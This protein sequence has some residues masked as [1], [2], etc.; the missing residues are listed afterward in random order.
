MTEDNGRA[1]ARRWISRIILATFLALIILSLPAMCQRHESPSFKYS[2]EANE[3]YSDERHQYQPYDH[4]HDH[5]HVHVHDHEHEHEHEEHDPIR[6]DPHGHEYPP[7]KAS[8]KPSPPHIKNYKDIVVRAIGST[9]IISAAPFL[10]LFFVP[11]DNTEQSEW[12]LKILLSFASGGLLGD[13]FLHLIPHAMIPHSHGSSETH[14]HSHSNSHDEPGHHKHDI[15]VGL[16]ILLGLIVFLMVEKAVR[17]VKG[18]HGHS[19]EKK[20]VLV[21]K[22]EGKKEERKEEKKEGKK[23][24]KKE[25]KKNSGKAVSKACKTPESDIKIA[26]YLN[27]AADFLHNF[28]DGL[29]IGASYMAGDSIGYVTTFMILLHEIPHEIGDFA[30]LIQSGYSKSKAMKMQ[31]VTA[32]GALLGTFISLLAEGMGDFATK[33]ILPFTAGG[34]IYIATVSVIPELLTA[35]KLWQSVQE[36]SALLVGVSLMVFMSNIE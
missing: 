1:L 16:S 25:E 28:T 19:H 12:L 11:L 29:A 4:D 5:D 36:I 34:F 33:W 15:S 2:K 27:L 22:R 8:T 18:D 24:E 7:P 31:L 6:Y 17:I 14:S 26:G 21:E 3:I 32:I 35:T 10:I 20:N 13:A 9:L 30:I 23:Q